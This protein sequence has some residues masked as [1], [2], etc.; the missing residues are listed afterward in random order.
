MKQYRLYVR[1]KPMFDPTILGCI[2]PDSGWYVQVV[3]E[4]RVIH[5]S[6]VYG[7]PLYEYKTGR[8]VSSRDQAISAAM[9][10]CR[11]NGVRVLSPVSI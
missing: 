10:W 9:I 1:Y 3:I 11:Q 7:T 6:A 8:K 4:D 5:T 2:N